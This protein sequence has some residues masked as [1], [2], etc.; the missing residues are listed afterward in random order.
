MTGE[1]CAL[2]RGDSSDTPVFGSHKDA[3][4]FIN[5]CSSCSLVTHRKCFMDWFRSLEASLMWLDNSRP[6]NP[7]IDLDQELEENGIP[8]DRNDAR[9]LAYV[10]YSSAMQNGRMHNASEKMETSAPCPQCKTPI[11]FEMGELPLINYYEYVR[12]VLY[13]IVY[14][15][16]I[17]LTVTGAGTGIV[18]MMYRGLGQCGLSIVDTI[19]PQSVVLPEIAGTRL[20]WADIVMKPVLVLLGRRSLNTFASRRPH[21]DYIPALPFIM[22]RMRCLLI[23][24]IL[25]NRKKATV[26]DVLN[27]VQVC[28]FFSSMGGH[29]L[30]RQLWRNASSIFGQWRSGTLPFSQMM[31][32]SLFRNI[33]WTDP[34]VMIASV[35]PVRWI[36]DLVYHLTVNRVYLNITASVAPR[37]IVNSLSVKDAA[38][39]E[40][41]IEVLNELESDLNQKVH[42]TLTGKSF[43]NSISRK[44]F[45]M[46]KYYTDELYFK[47]LKLK[48]LLWFQKMKACLKN[49]YSSSLV[50][51][52]MVITAIS[53]VAWPYIGADIGKIILHFI[54]KMPAFS[55]VEVGK[56]EFLSNLAGMTLVALFKDVANLLLS[57]IKAGQISTINIVSKLPTPDKKVRP[58]ADSSHFPGAY[59][60]LS[61]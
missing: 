53:T 42:K 48:V 51:H 8:A 10:L 40:L 50:K 28:N 26:L 47:I 5:P 15:G 38:K 14:Y 44:C 61:L 35:V 3:L 32:S 45:A 39:F 33:D 34:S 31:L 30:A 23:F 56:L 52:L 22:Y 46:W 4:D 2:C 60:N 12:S 11:L 29:V 54:S 9:Y 41:L 55:S 27:E 25:F 58:G 37:S 36:Y 1:I 21:Y 16:G 57:R 20:V 13:D 6:R 59:T 7:A 24:E 49:D 43:Y 17:S 18:V 19:K